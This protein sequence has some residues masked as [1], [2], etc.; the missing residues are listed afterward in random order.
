[1]KRKDKMASCS[2]P[3]FKQITF[4]NLQVLNV[5][6]FNLYIKIPCKSIL[7]SL[8]HGCLSP[9]LARMKENPGKELLDK[10]QQVLM[11]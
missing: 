9:S 5:N 7:I 4:M 11:D 10:S 8:T 3:F 6:H 1:M 2:Q